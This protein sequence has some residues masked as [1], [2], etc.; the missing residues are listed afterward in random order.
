M[1][2]VPDESRREKDEVK[3]ARG[4]ERGRRGHK[5]FRFPFCMGAFLEESGDKA[6]GHLRAAS[7]GIR[8]CLE[9]I[10]FLTVKCP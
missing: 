2:S 4:E 1:V 9:Q 3:D 8:K 6:V 5:E 10:L 7:S